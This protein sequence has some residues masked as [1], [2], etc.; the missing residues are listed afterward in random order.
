LTWELSKRNLSMNYNPL[1]ENII[2]ISNN[3]A[4]VKLD[5]SINT[6]IK[7]ITKGYR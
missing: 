7:G 3:E 4:K 2:V 6:K 1:T 5:I